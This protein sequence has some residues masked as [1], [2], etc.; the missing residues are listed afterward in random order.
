MQV[1]I[2]MLEVRA[3]AAANNVSPS[4]RTPPVESQDT[5]IFFSSNSSI[6]FKIVGASPYM[7]ATPIRFGFMN[8]PS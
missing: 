4:R 7:E 5:G 2:M 1:P 8:Y 3:A 6:R